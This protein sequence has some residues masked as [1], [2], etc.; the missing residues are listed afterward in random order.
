MPRHRPFLQ[1]RREDLLTFFFDILLAC[2]HILS[3]KNVTRE[4]HVGLPI[5]RLYVKTS[6]LESSKPICNS[7]NLLSQEFIGESTA[8]NRQKKVVP[9]VGA[10]L[11][12]RT[13]MHLK[14]T[15]FC[16][17]QKCILIIFE[18][19]CVLNLWTKS[20]HCMDR[21]RFFQFINRAS[22]RIILSV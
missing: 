8:L 17:I 12:Y 19:Y 7:L 14:P 5:A 2:A 15:T 22:K 11:G 10:M 21:R 13:S 4:R 3:N 18:P 20:P 1:L 6:A 16:P 9:R